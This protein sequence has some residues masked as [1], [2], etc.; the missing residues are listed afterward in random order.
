M[1]SSNYTNAKKIWHSIAG[2]IE[3]KAMQFLLEIDKQLLEILVPSNYYYYYVFNIKNV[4]FD[5]FHPKMA[6]ILG[7]K[8]SQITV[9][10]I[11]ELIHP[12]DQI[13][14]LNFEKKVGEFFNQLSLNQIPNYKVCYDY[15]IRKSNNEYIR[16]LQQSIAIDFDSNG[17]LLRSFCIHTDISHL[18]THG[19]PTLSFLGLNEEPSYINVD[20]N[21]VFKNKTSL[22]TR[23][24]R[25]VLTLIIQG[26][27]SKEIS[28]V[29]HISKQTV[30]KH[31]KNIMEKTNTKN[32]AELVSK[33]IIYGWV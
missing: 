32:I 6:S 14:F 28:N 9:V 23:R 3:D 11:F 2:S 22:V 13:W 7:Y 16:I 21:E 8:Q 27:N 12:D 1:K 31:R 4:A 5:Y 30:D 29:L 33:T 10:T 15:R 19:K 24:E 20:V 17:Q 25:D 26:L 18:K